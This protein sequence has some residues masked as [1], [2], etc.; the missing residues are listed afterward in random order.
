MR[1]IVV[2]AILVF[3]SVL[4]L[5]AQEPRSV[6][7]LGSDPA[8]EKVSQIKTLQNIKVHIQNGTQLKG[9]FVAASEDGIVLRIKGGNDMRVRREE[10][11]RISWRSHGM[12][13]LIG[14]GMGAGIGAAVGSGYNLMHD[15][16]VTRGESAAVGIFMFGLPAALGGGIVGVER[17]IYRNPILPP[18]LQ[19]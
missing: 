19:K 13:A 1:K 12:G 2:T 16:G 5:S 4:H 6:G 7:V 3:G 9:K 18:K 11:Q 15:T 14:L 17:T 10:I 8:W